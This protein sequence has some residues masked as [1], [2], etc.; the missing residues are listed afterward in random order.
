MGKT[1]KSKTDDKENQF[2]KKAGF[3]VGVIICLPI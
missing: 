3:R 2:G 1:D